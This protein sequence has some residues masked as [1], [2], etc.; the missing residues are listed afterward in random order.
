M[1]SIDCGLPLANRALTSFVDISPSSSIMNIPVT[2]PILAVDASKQFGLLK[3]KVAIPDE[4]SL[5]LVSFTSGTT[6]SW[7]PRMNSIEA[8]SNDVDEPRVVNAGLI[9]ANALAVA[10]MVVKIAKDLMVKVVLEGLC[11]Y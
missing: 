7:N 8:A 6:F 5:A 3:L 9:G 2:S 1:L 11:A 10:R 4:P